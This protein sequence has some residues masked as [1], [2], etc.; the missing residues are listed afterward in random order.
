MYFKTLRFL[1]QN[2]DDL[3]KSFGKVE[4]SVHNY[5]FNQKCTYLDVMR[6]L[7]IWHLILI[8]VVL[9]FARTVF[10]EQTNSL[11]A[12]SPAQWLFIH[13]VHYCMRSIRLAMSILSLSVF[14]VYFFRTNYRFLILVYMVTYCS[15]GF[16]FI[17]LRN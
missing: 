4:Y 1:A 8:T 13:F 17:I 14:K 9:F 2:L 16:N 10:T 15:E 5:R 7:S 3:L 6:P 11:P 12:K